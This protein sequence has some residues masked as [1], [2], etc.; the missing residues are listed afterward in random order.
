MKNKLFDLETES[1]SEEEE[2]SNVVVENEI[3]VINNEDN[4]I[5]FDDDDIECNEGE[6]KDKCDSKV[7]DEEDELVVG[8]FISQNQRTDHYLVNWNNVVTPFSSNKIM[9][10]GD[11]YLNVGKFVGI[12]GIHDEGFI[13]FNK[14]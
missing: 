9:G 12:F 3:G 2:Q 8:G 10:G 5:E 6:D 1:E 11:H 14:W 13:N 7:N 4:I